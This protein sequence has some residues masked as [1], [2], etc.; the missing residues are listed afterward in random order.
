MWVLQ[1]KA[2]PSEKAMNA[3][4]CCIYLLFK[5]K[6]IVKLKVDSIVLVLMNIQPR[7]FVSFA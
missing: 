2:G 6:I 7:S 4:N 1:I 3:L 5:I